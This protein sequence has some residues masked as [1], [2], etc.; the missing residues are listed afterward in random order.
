METVAAL[1]ARRNR[2]IAGGGGT[3]GGLNDTAMAETLHRSVFPACFLGCVNMISFFFC[4]NILIRE[5][6]EILIN[7]KFNKKKNK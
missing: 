2:V 5:G 1:W 7:L 6:K 4:F 3:Y